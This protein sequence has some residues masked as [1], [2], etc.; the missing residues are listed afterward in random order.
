MKIALVLHGKSG[1]STD[2]DE[3]LSYDSNQAIPFIKK[4]ILENNDVDIFYHTW[5]EGYHKLWEDNYKPKKFLVEKSKKFITPST[6]DVLRYWKKHFMSFFGIYQ[7]RELNYN[8]NIYSRWYSFKESLNLLI[9]YSKVE[10]INYDFV[11]CSRFDFFLTKRINFDTLDKSKFYSSSEILFVDD[12]KIPIQPVSLYLKEEFNREKYSFVE[13]DYFNNPINGMNDLFQMGSYE[14]MIQLKDLFDKLDY[15]IKTLKIPN[16]NHHLLL[17]H[18]VE[19]KLE[20]L[21]TTILYNRLN[22]GL[23]RWMNNKYLRS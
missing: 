11:I 4:N 15:Y 10:N 21:R 23:T 17:A 2:K 7:K 5:E 20:P 8:N 18:L 9:N 16:S 22:C 1:G 12:Y 13:V 3:K 6:K 19:K 14:N